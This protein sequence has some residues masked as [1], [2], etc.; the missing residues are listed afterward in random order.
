VDCLY[1]SACYLCYVQDSL[2]KIRRN[3][4]I[5]SSLLPHSIHARKNYSFRLLSRKNL[6]LVSSDSP[7]NQLT[8]TVILLLLYI[9]LKFNSYSVKKSFSSDSAWF[10][11]L[12]QILIQI[13]MASLFKQI[14]FVPRLSFILPPK[15]PVWN[16]QRE[17]LDFEQKIPDT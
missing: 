16:Y 13:L 5:S 17:S 15:I 11:S 6:S 12:S 8:L 4:A 3:A 2:P 1:E 9:Y 7:S 10:Q 14:W